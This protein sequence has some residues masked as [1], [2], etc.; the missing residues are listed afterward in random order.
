MSKIT[1]FE[2]KEFK[3]ILKAAHQRSKNI[4][5]KAAMDTI[6]DKKTLKY[7]EIEIQNIDKIMY[8]TFKESQNRL[9]KDAPT[10]FRNVLLTFV[11]DDQP[12][13]FIVRYDDKDGKSK[14]VSVC[15]FHMMTDDEDQVLVSVHYITKDKKASHKVK[16]VAFKTDGENIFSFGETDN[17]ETKLIS[18]AYSLQM[19]VN[20]YTS[21]N[22][23]IPEGEELSTGINDYFQSYVKDS[24]LEIQE[25]KK[26]IDLSSAISL[27]N[28][29]E[30][31]S[32][33]SFASNS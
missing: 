5:Y 12:A 24:L 7:S 33:L 2:V 31:D 1:G 19:L 25:S 9:L 21:I 32:V 6:T 4:M 18:F 27:L 29:D 30:E 3:R 17:F 11:M 14:S 26:D 22:E 23:E 13:C 16:Q 15:S 28:A 8:K 20:R 10:V